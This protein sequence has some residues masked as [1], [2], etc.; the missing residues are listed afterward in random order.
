MC[1]ILSSYLSAYASDGACWHT[2][3]THKSKHTLNPSHTHTHT[4]HCRVYSANKNT[5]WHGKESFDNS[6][7]LKHAGKHTHTLTHICTNEQGYKR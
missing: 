4:Q 6:P 1:L 7:A 3:I 5:D 2:C